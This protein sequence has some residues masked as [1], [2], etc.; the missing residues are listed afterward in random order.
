MNHKS[1]PYIKRRRVP[2]A[3]V[4][5]E[6]YSQLKHHGIISVPEHR[7]VIE[8]TNSAVKPDLCI[9]QG[10]RIIA[11]VECKSKPE[12]NLD[13]INENTRQHRKYVDLGIPFIYCNH[14]DQVE[15]TIKD[16]LDFYYRGKPFKERGFNT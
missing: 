2:S 1:I 6:I 10:K 9:I 15:Q 12:R 7:L 8:K 4:Q 16:I 11:C 14:M 3:M 5:C 13:K